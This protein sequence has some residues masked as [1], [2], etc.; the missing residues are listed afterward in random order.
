MGELKQIEKFE[1][2]IF[3]D[4]IYIFRIQKSFVSPSC[5]FIKFLITQNR[6][7]IGKICGWN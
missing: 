6:I 3:D 7:K 5:T 4:Y 2:N 1:L